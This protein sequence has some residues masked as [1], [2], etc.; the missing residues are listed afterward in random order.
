MENLGVTLDIRYCDTAKRKSIAPVVKK[1]PKDI[2]PGQCTELLGTA[3]STI[4]VENLLNQFSS[5]LSASATSEKL[6]VT[7]LDH[8]DTTNLLQVKSGKTCKLQI[9]N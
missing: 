7:G 8:E 1:E 9:I 2:K 6:V 4:L 5:P 3:N